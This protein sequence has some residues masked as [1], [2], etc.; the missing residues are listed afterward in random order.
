MRRFS[1]LVLS[2]VA[3]ATLAAPLAAAKPKA[4]APELAN[5]EFAAPARGTASALMNLREPAPGGDLETMARGVL[6]RHAGELGFSAGTEL[7]LQ[8]T[9]HGKVIDV[10]RFRQL[11]AGLP[12]LRGGIAV[13]FNRRGE[14]IYVASDLKPVLG[15]LGELS[16]A[17][18]APQVASLSARSAAITRLGAD[19]AFNLDRTT[20]EIFPGA[21]GARVVWVSRLAPQG[22]PV[23]DWEVLIDAASGEV[24][25]VEDRALYDD[26]QG[27]AFLPD[28]LSSAGALYTDPG[29]AD[30]NDANTTQLTDEIFEITLRDIT[31]SGVYS[32]KGPYAD[33]QGTLEAPSAA[34]ATSATTDFRLSPVN[35][36]S[37]LFEEM[38]VYYHIDTYMRYINETLGIPVTPF[39][40]VGGV[41]FDPHG[42][43]GQDNSHYTGAG[44]VA[45]GDG[46]VDDS[47]DADV[48]IHE[49]G[50]GLHDWLT[51]GS[52]SQADGLSEG[53][54]DYVAVSYSRGFPGQWASNVAQY[55]WVFSWDGHNPFWGGRVTTWNDDHLYTAGMGGL[56]T[57][58]QFWASCNIDIAEQ[59]GYAAVDEAMFEGISMTGGSTNHAQAAQ[60][61]MQAAAELGYGATT[62]ATMAG[63]YNTN[64]G[65]AGCNYGV[66]IPTGPIFTDDF[67]RGNF[68][69]WSSIAP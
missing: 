38:N 31:L 55:N 16:A 49:L 15:D 7:E 60:A 52:L 23:G 54:G 8:S 25:R 39:Q 1:T 20:L 51:G 37:D 28:P 56:H 34:C 64:S 12:V 69:R 47:E 29:Y 58:G 44:I 42:L 3:F 4:S 33:C 36:E 59:I 32:L 40:Y 41:K 11:A 68:S 21:D 19:G 5:P 63:I 26:G 43:S 27:Q 45:F 62:L 35:R 6:A 17:A 22:T 18:A 67:E 2:A 10:V 13:S 48:V 24:V 53:F 61:V 65:A 66:T 9:R 50:H 14:A 46:G 30:G 57:T